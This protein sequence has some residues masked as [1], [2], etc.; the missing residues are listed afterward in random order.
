M[1]EKDTEAAEFD[2][3]V[4]AGLP[5]SPEE[6]YNPSLSF[7]GFLELGATEA[8]TRPG[9]Y[10]PKSYSEEIHS[11]AAP[12]QAFQPQFKVAE[13]G[14]GE[15][16]QAIQISLKRPV[17]LKRVKRCFVEEGSGAGDQQIKA[18]HTALCQEA[19]IT[20]SLEHPN[21]VP[22]HELIGSAERSPSIAMK[23]VN[24]SAWSTII[25]N[26]FTSLSFWRS[27]SRFSSAWVRPWPSP[28][29]RE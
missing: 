24:G 6:T 5:E 9:H 29:P 1:E 20:A 28:I 21:I 26:D 17:A 7:N 27:T 23:L 15:I 12:E 19:V 14:H 2:K 10:L 18:L 3:D 11:P 16:W 25:Q 13:G 8:E 22:V 4:P